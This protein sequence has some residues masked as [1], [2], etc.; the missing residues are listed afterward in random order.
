MKFNKK[1]EISDADKSLFWII[2]A[3][4]VLGILITIIF[5]AMPKIVDA[6]T[7]ISPELQQRIYMST[8]IGSPLCFAYEDETINR[9][10][11]GYV[12]IDK[13]TTQRLHDCLNIQRRTEIGFFVKLTIDGNFVKEIQTRN[14]LSRIGARS[15]QIDKPVIVIDGDKKHNGVLT[16][17]FY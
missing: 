15:T 10:Y 6:Q 11:Q 7:T 3:L 2:F 5:I 17:I 1:A 16:Y 12:D 13:I 8:T 14:V 4:P 9:I